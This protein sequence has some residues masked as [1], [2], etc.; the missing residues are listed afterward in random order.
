MPGLGKTMVTQI[1]WIPET[2]DKTAQTVLYMNKNEQQNNFLVDSV[3]RWWCTHWGWLFTGA[4]IIIY[5][6]TR[7]AS[8][9]STSSSYPFLHRLRSWASPT[10]LLPVSP[11]A[12]PAECWAGGFAAEYVRGHGAKA[13]RPADGA[14]GLRAS[15]Q[16]LHAASSGAADQTAGRERLQKLGE[17]LMGLLLAVC[18]G[19]IWILLL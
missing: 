1:K 16:G 8:S 3:L 12:S 18:P 5:L 13:H 6:K 4:L 11:T 17:C 19:H 2:K 14:G 15:P 10:V 7:Y 9:S